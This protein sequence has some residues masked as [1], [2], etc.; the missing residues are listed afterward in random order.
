MRKIQ[1]QGGSSTC[2]WEAVW[3][4]HG[5]SPHRMRPFRGRGNTVR[6]GRRARYSQRKDESGRSFM[7]LVMSLHSTARSQGL[8]RTAG[9]W[10]SLASG[11]V[12]PMA[13]RCWL[14]FQGTSQAERHYIV[15]SVLMFYV[16]KTIGRVK[17]WVWHW[18]AFEWGGGLRFKEVSNGGPVCRGHLH[19]FI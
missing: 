3:Q 15:K 8:C 14:Q 9:A 12:F 6:K 11:L 4:T 16:C 5:D 19:S 13:S 17:V 2:V 1:P 7:R 18:Q 10:V